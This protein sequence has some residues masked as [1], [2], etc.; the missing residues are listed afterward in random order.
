MATYLVYGTRKSD[1]QDDDVEM[2]DSLSD[3]DETFSEP[4]P[5]KTLQL[6]REETL[7]G[8]FPPI[9]GNVALDNNADMSL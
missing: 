4:V 9:H 3:K 1:E 8:K 7:Q 6:I 5:T 2:T